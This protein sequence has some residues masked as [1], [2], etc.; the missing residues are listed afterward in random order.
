MN[1]KGRIKMD[2]TVKIYIPNKSRTV[3]KEENLW[4]K[5]LREQDER[6]HK[7]MLIYP[8][9]VKILN[10][11]ILALIVALMVGFAWWGFQVHAEKVSAE[12][13]QSAMMAKRAEEEAREQQRQAELL[14]QQQAKAAQQENERVLVAK[15]LAGIDSFV[16]KYGYSEGDIKTYAE[17]VINR[18][19]NNKSGFGNTISEVVLQKS[20][21]VGFSEDNQLIDKYYKI[22]SEVVNNYYSGAV[23]PCSSDYCWAELRR[24][25]IYLK[26]EFTDS[27]YVRTWRY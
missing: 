18:V 17:C 9:A 16:E 15:L 3:V 13:A 21:W 26:N 24:D 19:I 23:R 25:G 12:I 5:V 7:L 27:K 1:W 14:A 22:A 10:G 2:Q 11:I 20:Q 8:T 6:T 4:K